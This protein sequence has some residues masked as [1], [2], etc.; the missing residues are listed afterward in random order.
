MMMGGTRV[1]TIPAVSGEKAAEMKQ[2]SARS[3]REVVLSAP[4]AEGRGVIRPRLPTGST[5]FAEG[6]P[7]RRSLPSVTAKQRG[8]A[9]GR[10]AGLL[11]C[12]LHGEGNVPEP[13]SLAEVV[14]ADE[15]L[16]LDVIMNVQDKT[17][18]GIHRRKTR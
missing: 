9:I 2:A 16:N 8:A 7:L 18:T 1:N 10:A 6:L 15:F 4:I 17:R 5:Q 11:L 14:N 3:F 12:G 13:E